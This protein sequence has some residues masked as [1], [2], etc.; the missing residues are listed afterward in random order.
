MTRYRILSALLI[1]IS[2]LAAAAVGQTGS[3]EDT[4]L[5]LEREWSKRFA[6]G[7]VD[8]IVAAHASDAQ[9]FPPNAPPVVGID[10]LRSAWQGMADTEGLS[11]SWQPTRAFVSGSGD[12]AWDYGAGKLTTSEGRTQDVKYVVVWHRIAGEWKIVMDMFSPNAG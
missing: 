9:Q 1:A 4:I 8:W 3:E 12:M 5:A 10:A 6:L 7:D 2:A 11:L